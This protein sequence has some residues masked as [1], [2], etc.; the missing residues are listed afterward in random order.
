[1]SALR[2]YLACVPPLI[3]VVTL[4]KKTVLC[5]TNLS[6]FLGGKSILEDI[7]FTLGKG[8]VLGVLG[9][10]GAG[11]TSLLRI[12]SGQR[13]SLGE[14]T[15]KGSRICDYSVQELAR[16]IAVVNQI[17]DPVFALTLLHV[18]RMGLLPHKSLLSR[19]TEDDDLSIARA[20]K[21]VGLED[22]VSQE[23]NSLSGG[24]Q[25]RAL[26]AR[27]LVQ[28]SPLLILDEPVNHLDVFYQHQILQLLHELARSLGITVIMSL[29]DLNLAS[30]YCDKLCLLSKG[31][32]VSF[33]SP[34]HVLEAK[35]LTEVFGLPCHVEHN[36]ESQSLNVTF[37]PQQNALLNLQGWQT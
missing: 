28:G 25:Q 24:E 13:D 23:F 2:F 21:A 34:Q 36:G 27:A 17:N 4:S 35:R 1:M 22:K 37:I 8:E 33:G 19:Q 18:V 26:I 5:A 10:N 16:Q 14:V 11:K 32:L 15:W 31:Q 20:I 3:R 6:L 29:H 30:S 9:P 12:L 7:S